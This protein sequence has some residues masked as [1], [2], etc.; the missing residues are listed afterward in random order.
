MSS[1]RAVESISFLCD[2]EQLDRNFVAEKGS[3][4][5]PILAKKVQRPS[6]SQNHVDST[7]LRAPKFSKL[8]KKKRH[9]GYSSKRK[10]VGKTVKRGVRRIGACGNMGVPPDHQML[11]DTQDKAVLSKPK[12]RVDILSVPFPR[13]LMLGPDRLVFGKDIARA[14]DSTQ[15][16][17]QRRFADLSRRLD[18]DGY[19]LIRNV[20]ARTKAYAAQQ[21]LLKHLINKGA[22]VPNPEIQDSFLIAPDFIRL[23]GWTVDAESGGVVDDREPK[24]A[25]R[26]WSKVGEKLKDFYKGEELSDLFGGLFGKDFV[27]RSDCTWLRAK[28]KGEYTQQHCDYYY[29]KNNTDLISASRKN[30]QPVK[31]DYDSLICQVCG[32]RK[33]KGN[34]SHNHKHEHKPRDLSN[35]DAGADIPRSARAEENQKHVGRGSG[36]A[37]MGSVEGVVDVESNT[38]SENE[39]T[40][41]AAHVNEAAQRVQCNRSE[42]PPGCV[43]HCVRHNLQCMASCERARNGERGEATALRDR[44]DPRVAETEER[45]G[46]GGAGGSESGIANLENCVSRGV[47]LVD[48]GQV[49]GCLVETAKAVKTDKESGKVNE[50]ERAG[51][52]KCKEKVQEVTKQGA[53][54]Q[55]AKT[56][57]RRVEAKEEEE[58]EALLCDLCDRC[59]HVNCVLPPLTSIPDGEWHCSDCANSPLSLFTC[60]MP[61]SDISPEGSLLLSPGSH[62]LS[63]YDSPLPG[64]ELLPLEWRDYRRN[65][66]WKWRTVAPARPG[67][68]VLF[69]IKTVHAASNNNFPAFRLSCDTRVAVKRFVPPSSS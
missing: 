6:A 38:P 11:L 33:A 14:Q 60:W 17:K 4:R 54:G 9:N 25:V 5:K 57:E 23:P 44:T 41:D 51:T 68:L 28:C 37:D 53:E 42:E 36:T 50:D 62:N 55:R 16:F 19:I 12:R 18:K 49:S 56:G 8:M 30:P 43:N 29:F 1:S 65:G 20:I 10:R 21:V 2:L 61:L 34:P 13:S 48:D 63:G 59:F 45:S 46:A 24:S 3:T 67:D 52:R 31:F 7:N 22:A 66:K 69:N 47:A 15:L 26:G 40:V 64:K 32:I 27:L 35:P 58:E 39:R